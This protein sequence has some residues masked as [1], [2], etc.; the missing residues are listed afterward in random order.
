MWFSVVV[1]LLS[2]LVG[3]ASAQDS[4]SASLRIGYLDT[5]ETVDDP[6]SWAGT[7]DLY[8]NLTGRF[9]LGLELGMNRFTREDVTDKYYQVV[10][11]L[12]NRET[13]GWVR[14]Y[15]SGGGGLYLFHEGAFEREYPTAHV[16]VQPNSPPVIR[17][18]PGQTGYV[19]SMGWTFGLGADFDVLPGPFF[20]EGDMRGHLVLASFSNPRWIVASIGVGIDWVGSD[21]G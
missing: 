20:I 11:L 21:P 14:P 8:T 5:R 17:L 19:P 4:N 7:A 9:G 12:R 2:G 15:F 13:W 18:D 3:S 10:F 16:L 1:L 6:G